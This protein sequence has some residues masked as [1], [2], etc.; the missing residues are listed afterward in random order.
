MKEITLQIDD[1]AANLLSTEIKQKRATDYSN[2]L[3]DKFLIRL[4]D[5]LANNT[6]VMTL[7]MK[8]NK[9]IIRNSPLNQY[10]DH[11]QV[12]NQNGEISGA[13]PQP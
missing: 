11:R 12:R 5:S 3:G 8:D 13:S 4:F 7:S 9:I 6:K 10:D 2:G 1:A